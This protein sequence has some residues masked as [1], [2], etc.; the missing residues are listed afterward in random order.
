MLAWLGP[1][2]RRIVHEALVHV[3]AAP[4]CYPSPSSL[5]PPLQAFRPNIQTG[6]L[7]LHNVPRSEGSVYL[8]LFSKLRD[9]LCSR[10]EGVQ[11]ADEERRCL[12]WPGRPGRILRLPK[13]CSHR[14]SNP[15]PDI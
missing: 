14:A 7:S 4:P 10:F 1:V 8:N 15:S 3:L 11:T 6:H 2:V 12:S 9:H 13:C 5:R